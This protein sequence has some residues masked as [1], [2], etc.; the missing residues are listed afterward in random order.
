MTPEHE[1]TRIRLPVFA[2]E[3]ERANLAAFAA[4]ARHEA[5]TKCQNERQ[6]AC[7]LRRLA[8]FADALDEARREFRVGT[9][10]PA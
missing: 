6:A 8:D 4:A 5:T 7:E 3:F 10:A 2:R 9:G 1:R